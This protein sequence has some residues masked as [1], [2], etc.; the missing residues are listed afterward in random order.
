MKHREMSTWCILYGGREHVKYEWKHKCKKV[1]MIIAWRVVGSRASICRLS[2][3]IIQKWISCWMAKVEKGD[4][5]GQTNKAVTVS[6]NHLFADRC[7]CSLS[8]S[9]WGNKPKP[10]QCSSVDAVAEAIITVIIGISSPGG[11]AIR[12]HVAQRSC[13]IW[14]P[15]V[16]PRS[17]L[18]NFHICNIHVAEC[19][20]VGRRVLG[21]FD[22]L[23]QAFIQ[24]LHRTSL[25]SQESSLARFAAWKICTMFAQLDNISNM[26]FSH[27]LLIK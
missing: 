25:I 2:F 26:I 18:L 6:D 10:L 15:W 8:G 7:W 1:I 4:C 22:V 17:F 13:Y 3:E 27:G 19:I 11:D 14:L 12:L 21:V 23:I 5:L 20:S 16:V 24:I 9:V